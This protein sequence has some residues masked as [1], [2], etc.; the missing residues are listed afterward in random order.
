MANL[1]ALL[2]VQYVFIAGQYHTRLV[3]FAQVWVVFV[4]L[5]L[6]FSCVLAKTYRVWRVFDNPKA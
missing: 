3:C 1:G 2:S 4:G 6:F 5:S